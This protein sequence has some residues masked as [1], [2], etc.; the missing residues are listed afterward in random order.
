M[1]LF[2]QP[3]LL[4]GVSEETLHLLISNMLMCHSVF[5]CI[6]SEDILSLSLQSECIWQ[7]KCE[8]T[9]YSL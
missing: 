9:R 7:L 6:H 8:G 5:P 4:I 3:L 1:L 2:K